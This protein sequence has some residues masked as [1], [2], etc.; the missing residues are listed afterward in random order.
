MVRRRQNFGGGV[1]RGV[2]GDVHDDKMT[3]IH[4][5]PLTRE[6]VEAKVWAFLACDEKKRDRIAALEQGTR[7]WLASRVLRMTVSNAGTAVGNN[8]YA[9]ATDYANDLAHLSEPIDPESEDG[10]RRD[11]ALKWGH[12]NEDQAC[13]A[14]TMMMKMRLEEEEGHEVAE[15]FEVT[16][17]GL[18][19]DLDRVWMGASPDGLVFMP[20][21]KAGGDGGAGTESRDKR[22]KCKGLLEI[23]CP[24][25]KRIYP[26]IPPY[27]YDQITAQM[28]I[29]KRDWCDFCV[30]T[31]TDMVVWH[32]EFDAKYWNEFLLPRL[33]SFYHDLFLPHYIDGV[34]AGKT[35]LPEDLVKKI[36]AGPAS[37]KETEDAKTE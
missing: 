30:W 15:Q 13:E 27:Y 25:T 17:C 3:D 24:V 28:A 2:M 20:P 36:M 16:H 37:H 18:V 11:A 33:E 1:I 5:P 26:H 29:L 6:E 19:V 14:Y 31:P 7:E 10:K 4:T 23:K 32:F 8:P 9:K 34:L 22:S 21:K 12:D 35:L